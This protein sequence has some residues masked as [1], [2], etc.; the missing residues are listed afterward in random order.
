MSHSIPSCIGLLLAFSLAPARAAELYVGAGASC[1]YKTI[2]AAVDAV[3]TPVGGRDW[4][5][6][7][8]V[9][10]RRYAAQRVQIT[11]R[12]V[13]LIGARACPGALPAPDAPARTPVSGDGQFAVFRADNSRVRLQQLEISGGG[14]GVILAAA[15]LAVLQDVWVHG[16]LVFGGVVM[17]GG[18]GALELRGAELS[19]NHADGA[20]GGLSVDAQ[21]AGTRIDVTIVDDPALPTDIHHNRAGFGGGIALAGDVRLRAVA[22]APGRIRLRDNI[23]TGCGGGLYATGASVADLGLPG[24]S[25]DGNDVEPPLDETA[26]GTALCV[27][28]G[29]VATPVVRV[30]STDP[31]FPT[32]ISRNGRGTGFANSILHA[33]AADGFA[34]GVRGRICLWDA[35]LRLNQSSRLVLAREGGEILINPLGP[36]CDFATVQ[37]L[38]AM[39]CDPQHPDCN[40]V[41]GNDSQSP[42]GMISAEFGGRIGVGRMRILYNQA[43]SLLA[44]VAN[45]AHPALP[46]SRVDI[47]NSLVAYNRANAMLEN[48]GAIFSLDAI[49][50]ANN[51][52]QALAWNNIATAGPG[53]TFMPVTRIERSILDT[54]PAAATEV[55]G[56]P[57][58]ANFVLAFPPPSDPFVG[59]G[60]ASFDPRFLALDDFRLAP[61]SLA[62]DYASGSGAGALDLSARSRLVDLA[63]RSNFQGPHDLG[64]FERQRDDPLTASL[65]ANGFEPQ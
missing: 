41:E 19:G 5:T 23:A 12:N 29:G 36:E 32:V 42:F 43:T 28:G 56:Q 61:D 11:D 7:H 55:T 50:V 4:T 63:E 53:T 57:V 27:V 33:R 24:E 20:G 16:N 38:G 35:S 3:A 22:S 44:A 62:L 17:F 18:S 47:T 30:F 8:I 2:Q 26:D 54:R 45:Y 65:F 31:A 25:L 21:N 14:T 49:T 13:A 1:P 10:D 40:R 58:Q 9:A 59:E 39:R 46:N 6:I 15:P 48:R 34:S 52:L 64:A 60:N 51:E 37:A